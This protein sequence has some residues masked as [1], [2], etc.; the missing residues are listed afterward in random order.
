MH[1]GRAEDDGRLAALRSTVERLSTRRF[2][3]D[4]GRAD[5]FEPDTI[6]CGSAAADVFMD[7]A[8][9]R[10]HFATNMA[11]TSRFAGH[12]TC[13]RL[14]STAKQAGSSPIVGRGG[15]ETA[16]PFRM[17]GVLSWNA[18]NWRWRMLHASEPVG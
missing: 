11:R 18:G 7:G 6:G 14:T 8:G 2:A 3:K 1:T 4:I 5:E 16:Y 9:V 13:W 12:G 15:V 17:S 10:K